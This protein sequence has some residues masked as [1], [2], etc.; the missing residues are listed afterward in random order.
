MNTMENSQTNENAPKEEPKKKPTREEIDK[1]VVDHLKFLR[2]IFKLSI[3]K[4]KRKGKN[5]EG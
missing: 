2:G 3:K 5:N 4:G 1:G